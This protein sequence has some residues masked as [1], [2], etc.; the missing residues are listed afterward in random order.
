MPVDQRV[1]YTGQARQFHHQAI[2]TRVHDVGLVLYLMEYAKD[3]YERGA[4]ELTH[5]IRP[6]SAPDRGV[7]TYRDN[8]SGEADLNRMISPS[9]EN[10]S[11]ET[12]RYATGKT[13]TRCYLDNNTFPFTIAFKQA[14]WA[15]ASGFIGPYERLG[16]TEKN[17]RSLPAAGVPFQVAEEHGYYEEIGVLAERMPRVA[18]LTRNVKK[19]KKGEAP[20]TP[21]FLD[22]ESSQIWVNHITEI[23]RVRLPQDM[24]NKTCQTFRATDINGKDW[25][26]VLPAG[27][28]TFRTVL[29]ESQGVK[30]YPMQ[31]FEFP[32]FIATVECFDVKDVYYSPDENWK[33]VIAEFPHYVNGGYALVSLRDQVVYDTPLYELIDKPPHP[34]SQNFKIMYVNFEPKHGVMDVNSLPTPASVKIKFTGENYNLFLAEIRKL[35]TGT[36]KKEH[37]YNTPSFPFLQFK[38]KSRSDSGSENDVHSLPASEEDTSQSGNS[39]VAG[40][41]QHEEEHH[42]HDDAGHEGGGEAPVQNADTNDQPASSEIVPPPQRQSLDVTGLPAW[43]SKQIGQSRNLKQD[44]DADGNVKFT[45]D[46]SITDPDQNAVTLASAIIEWCIMNATSLDRISVTWSVPRVRYVH[47]KDSVEKYRNFYPILAIVNINTKN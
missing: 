18:N 42:D 34:S 43:I 12:S 41:E 39:S 30:R 36:K 7:I 45:Y 40:D 32:T 37:W 9:P 23:A 44:T 28:K 20:I 2:A 1:D 16:M 6:G 38:K 22:A 24:L 25:K 13:Q 29:K 3:G 15:C 46:R 31:L 33:K 26:G 10:G 8:G 27:T 4:T 14:G 35:N 19:A 21:A 5:T 47:V 11:K 17:W